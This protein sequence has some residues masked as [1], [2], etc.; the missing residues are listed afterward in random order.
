MSKKLFCEHCG[1][2]INTETDIYFESDIDSVVYCEKCGEE[3]LIYSDSIY[4]YV[5]ESQYKDT[6]MDDE[7]SDL[8]LYTKYEPEGD[9][10]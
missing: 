7:I 6:Y 5:H 2:R 3:H 10:I 9:D 1:A 8:D 4:S